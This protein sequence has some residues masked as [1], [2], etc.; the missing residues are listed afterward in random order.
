MCDNLCDKPDLKKTELPFIRLFPYLVA[1]PVG[2]AIFLQIVETIPPGPL[3]GGV[4]LRVHIFMRVEQISVPD[5][6]LS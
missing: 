4:R 2:G 3:S 6:R 1:N 5:P